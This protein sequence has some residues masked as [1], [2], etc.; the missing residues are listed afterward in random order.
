MLGVCDPDAEIRIATQPSWP[1][2]YLL[3]A[4]ALGVPGAPAIHLVTGE[5]LDSLPDPVRD[6]IGW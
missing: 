5:Q 2:E 3:Q 1:F 4:V 6:E